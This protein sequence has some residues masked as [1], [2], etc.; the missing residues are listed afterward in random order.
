L[1]ETIRVSSPHSFSPTA[2]QPAIRS[3]A[4]GPW[5]TNCYVVTVPGSSTPDHC[6]IVDCGFEPE[7]LLDFVQQQRLKP[8]AIL[9]THAHLDHIGGLDA[10]LNRF[11]RTPVFIHEAEAGFCSDPMLNL[12]AMIGMDL[13]V[14]EPD[15]RLRDG[16]TLNLSG[17]TWRVLHTPGHSPGGV[18]FIHDDS[19]QALVGD[20]LFA[21][22]IGRIDFPTSDP[23]AMRRTIHDTLMKLP[24]DMAVH[25]GHGPSTTI[26]A[27]RASNPFVIGGF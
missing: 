12:S 22:S 25:P 20:T 27:E 13:R 9:L 19:R 3:F 7:T 21:G 11:G 26:G 10:A 15:N 5:E 14:T 1:L 2:A 16:D 6:W 8:Q 23:E 18:C 24:D 17:T 4:L